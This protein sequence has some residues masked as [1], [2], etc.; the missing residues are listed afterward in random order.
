MTIHEDIMGVR[1][2]AEAR[3][4]LV[5][6]YEYLQTEH[7]D[8]PDVEQEAEMLHRLIA[9][10]NEAQMHKF[11]W[12]PGD[13]Q[14]TR[15]SETEKSQK[16]RWEQRAHEDVPFNWAITRQE[17]LERSNWICWLC[18]E[19]IE[20]KPWDDNDYAS[21][22]TVDHVIPLSEGGSHEW[23]NVR[24]AHFSCNDDRRRVNKE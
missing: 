10:D 22:G 5:K 3:M 12:S 8:N 6:V 2:A 23:D 19:T 4:I 21:Y 17:V 11:V 13:T 1:T 18:E 20:D 9:G 15:I 24:A 7:D 16:R 14:E